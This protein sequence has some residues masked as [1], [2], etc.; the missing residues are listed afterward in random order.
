MSTL[1]AGDARGRRRGRGQP[2][3]GGPGGDAPRGVAVAAGLD[4]LAAAAPGRR[5]RR[6]RR[7]RDDIGEE[8]EE[9]DKI[10]RVLGSL[11]LL[12]GWSNWI[13]HRNMKSRVIKDKSISR[14]NPFGPLQFAIPSM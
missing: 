4:L 6:R 14:A 7:R 12:T 13:L 3:S 8:E 11:F 1:R 9:E 10:G 5:R 2:R